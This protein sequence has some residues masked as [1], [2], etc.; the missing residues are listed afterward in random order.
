MA[1]ACSWPPRVPSAAPEAPTLLSRSHAR[2]VRRCARMFSTPAWPAPPS[3]ATTPAGA[4]ATRA[5]S[6]WAASS[7]RSR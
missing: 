6:R 3:Q 2:A 5:T 1:G 4:V 7:T